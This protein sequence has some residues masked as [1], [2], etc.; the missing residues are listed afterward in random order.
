MDGGQEILQLIGELT[1]YSVVI[2]ITVSVIGTDHTD[3][4]I[5]QFGTSG[6][7]VIEDDTLVV[8]ECAAIVAQ[9]TATVEF[10]DDDL[11]GA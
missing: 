3:T 8:L 11:T 4:E 5:R 10:L 1:L 7:V 2:V 6:T 9:A